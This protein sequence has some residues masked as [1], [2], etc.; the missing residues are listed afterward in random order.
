MSVMWTAA[1][2]SGVLLQFMSKYLSGTIFVN[3]YIEGI[4]GIVGFLIGK[5]LQQLWRV[6]I[7]FI[8]SYVVTIVGAFG[9]FL[10]ESEIISPYAFDPDSERTEENKKH[11]L[12]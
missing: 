12:S 8:I 1:N 4:A 2:F 5:V 11:H 3:Y 10:F 9:I 6:K 7:S